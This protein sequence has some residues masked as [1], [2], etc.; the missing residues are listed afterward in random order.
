MAGY[1]VNSS[2]PL[3]NKKVQEF[4]FNA[5]V[6]A[7]DAERVANPALVSWS[8]INALPGAHLASSETAA[9]GGDLAYRYGMNS[10]L[11]GIGLTA[12]QDVLIDPQF[13]NQ[14][15]LLRPWSTLNSGVMELI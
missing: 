15:Q 5:L 12:A 13:G 3:L 4:D 10:A 6:N 14:A 7:F 8:L 1:D 11:T 9:L 2:D